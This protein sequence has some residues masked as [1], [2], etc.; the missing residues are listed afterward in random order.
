MG[1]KKLRELAIDLTD[2]QRLQIL[3]NHAISDAAQWKTLDDKMWCLEC[4]AQ[5]TGREAR[6]YR[7]P[8]LIA[9]EDHDGFEVECGTDGCHGS[10]L[11]FSLKPWWRGER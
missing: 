11:D 5:F 1:R 8:S 3:Q 6:I 9:D 7:A 2:E 10:P 4:D